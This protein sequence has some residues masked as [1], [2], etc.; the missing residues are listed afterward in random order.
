MRFGIVEWGLGVLVFLFVLNILIRTLINPLVGNTQ[1][2]NTGVATAP[3]VQKPIQPKTSPRDQYLEASRLLTEARF[4]SEKALDDIAV[5]NTEI[6]P[7]LEQP[8]SDNIASNQ[9]LVTKLAYVLNQNRMTEE[10]L[11]VGLEQIAQ[12]SNRVDQLSTSDNP[13]L[14][15]TQE[16]RSIRNLHGN[17]KIASN[18]WS[19]AVKRASA[20][21]R[22]SYHNEALPIRLSLQEQ[23]D[24]SIDA[25]VLEDLSEEQINGPEPEETNSAISI[26]SGLFGADSAIR[27]SE[28]SA[29]VKTTLAPFLEYRNIQP[30]L[31]GAS[32]RF[33]NTLD[34]APMSLSRLASMGALND[35]IDGLK[36]LVAIG[37]DR[38]LPEPKWHIHTMPNNWSE[39]DREFL[40]KAQQMLRDHGQALADEGLLSQ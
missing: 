5:W 11:K 9:D 25:Q 4:A 8:E 21:V 17:A 27:E 15:S 36:R 30:R 12:I 20:I 7:V 10:E 18:S 13:E 37:A 1:A 31:S 2:N 28:L 24:R 6:L 14:L 33:Q 32:I 38:K 35:S 3:A 19:R 40:K 29:D 26:D 39:D 23:M 34:S 22:Q 16:V